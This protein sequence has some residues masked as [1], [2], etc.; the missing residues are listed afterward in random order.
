[1]DV[2]PQVCAVPR[3]QSAYSLRIYAYVKQGCVKINAGTLYSLFLYV[4][5]LFVLTILVLNLNIIVLVNSLKHMAKHP[6]PNE[7][8]EILW[9]LI[10]KFVQ[11]L[12]IRLRTH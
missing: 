2:G 5:F 6:M 3:Y 4:V 7:E 10:H 9:M 1:M 12:G 11:Y 8:T